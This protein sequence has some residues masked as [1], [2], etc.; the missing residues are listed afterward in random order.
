MTISL[1]IISNDELKNVKMVNFAPNLTPGVQL[2]DARIIHCFK[3]HYS[4]HF[5]TDALQHEELGEADIYNI[6]LLQVLQMATA[7]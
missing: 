1:D 2:L 7:A 6:N 5:L 4:W 3:A